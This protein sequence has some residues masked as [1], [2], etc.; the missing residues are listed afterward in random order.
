M[1]KE[2]SM[3]LRPFGNTSMNVS[4][5]GLGAWQL[6]NPDWGISDRA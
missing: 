3:T 1:I 5:I 6:A 4:E 2:Y